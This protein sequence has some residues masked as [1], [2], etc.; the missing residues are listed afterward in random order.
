M[1]RMS[2][3]AMQRIVQILKMIGVPKNQYFVKGAAGLVVGIFMS[4]VA[5]YSNVLFEGYSRIL[6]GGVPIGYTISRYEYLEKTKEF[7]GTH[8]VLTNAL[9]GS[10][11]E[12]Y[13][14]FSDE[15]F[16]AK[17]Y[18]YTFMSPTERK[19]IDVKKEKNK[20]VA[21][22]YSET[23]A[24]DALTKSSKGGGA[25]GVA[26]QRPEDVLMGIKFVKNPTRKI[27]KKVKKD[28]FFSSNVV[29]VL[30]NRPKTGSPVATGLKEKSSFPYD[31]A[32]AEEDGDVFSGVVTV[33][34]RQT[35][36]GIPVF[37]VESR[38]KEH[39]FIAA[40]TEKGEVLGTHS[41]LQ[42]ISTELVA[43]PDQATKNFEVPTNLFQT[44]FGDVPAGQVNIL[45]QRESEKTKSLI[46]SEKSGE[47]RK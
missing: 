2:L 37:K 33:D 23:A 44:I 19:T 40:V 10:I 42:S 39:K 4:S 45:A 20:W 27:S 8:F 22:I 3:E 28:L 32:I 46:S 41:P 18:Q 9:G 26:G 34:S 11:S 12:S 47:E 6:S 24:S 13:T 29:F 5:A 25:P 21:T 7:K 15:N 16:S 35:R 1:N 17:N 36:D 43:K 14:T 30:M 38:F 31:E